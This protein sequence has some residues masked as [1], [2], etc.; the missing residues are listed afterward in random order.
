MIPETLFRLKALL[1]EDALERLRRLRVLVVGVGA[2]GGACAEALA[3]S[4][5]GGLVLVDGD[6]FEVSNLNRQP[7]AAL[8]VLGRPKAEAAAA[9]LADC[10]P[11]CSVEAHSLFVAEDNVAA[12]LEKTRPDAVVDA[13]DDVPAKLALIAACRAWGLPVWSAMGCARKL[14]PSALRLTDIS[15]TAVCPL[16][17]TVRRGLRQRGIEKGVRCVWSAELPQKLSGGV[18]GSFM[19]VTATAGLL[20]AADLLR[21]VLPSS[22]DASAP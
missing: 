18:L 3:R 4:G 13:C 1:G 16:A 12:L 5:V 9:R 6:V 10:A 8:S 11:T 17:R 21:H 19:P 20:L 15:K 7:F 14:D 22:S 2:V